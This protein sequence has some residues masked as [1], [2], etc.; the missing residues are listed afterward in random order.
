[1]LD[2]FHQRCTFPVTHRG[3]QY[4]DTG[5][6][7]DLSY[8]RRTRGFERG[9]MIERTRSTKIAGRRRAKK[10]ARR[11]VPQIHLILPEPFTTSAALGQFGPCAQRQ[12]PIKEERA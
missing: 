3:H 10:P 7:D 4:H 11:A 6:Q 9:L 12:S 1:M 8:A 5:R 2:D